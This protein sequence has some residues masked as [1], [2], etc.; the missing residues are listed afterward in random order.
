MKMKN[1]NSMSIFNDK[2]QGIY[3]S[4]DYRSLKKVEQD[5]DLCIQEE[6]NTN[7]CLNGIER[8]R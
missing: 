5:Q 1:K 8:Y 7:R 6:Q 3:D 4:M 2:P